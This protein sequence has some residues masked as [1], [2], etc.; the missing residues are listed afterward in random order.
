MKAYEEGRKS[1]FKTPNK[2]NPYRGEARKSW[3]QG[4]FDAETYQLMQ[5]IFGTLKQIEHDLYT[6]IR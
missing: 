4:R 2:K 5:S 6:E 3:N 1:Y